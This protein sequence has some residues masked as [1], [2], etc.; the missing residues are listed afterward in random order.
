MPLI[1]LSQSLSSWGLL[2]VLALLL[3]LGTFQT[4]LTSLP[5]NN[6]SI[7]KLRCVVPAKNLLHLVKNSKAPTVP[8]WLWEP[9]LAD[10]SMPPQVSAAYG[11]WKV[12]QNYV[13][14][15]REEP[16]A[17]VLCS[18]KENRGGAFGVPRVSFAA[19]P[20]ESGQHMRESSL[21][22]AAPLWEWL[23]YASVTTLS[24]K[25]A[26]S[27]W[28]PGVWG[29]GSQRLIL[30]LVIDFRNTHV[31]INAYKYLMLTSWEKHVSLCS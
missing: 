5:H 6:P 12:I 29:D 25:H 26:L 16:E 1:V 31:T 23:K 9:S 20:L 3:P 30:A 21:L 18:G 8:H 14:L 13:S 19:R 11:S 2:I 27:G 10:H 15:K 22:P 7:F 28:E 17:T 4:S 24:Q